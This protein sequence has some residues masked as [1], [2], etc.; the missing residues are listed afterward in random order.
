MGDHGEGGGLEG[1][2]GLEAV[3]DREATLRSLLLDDLAGSAHE[4]GLRASPACERLV[5]RLTKTVLAW[6]ARKFDDAVAVVPELHVVFDGPPG[7][8]SGRFV[9]VEI[10]KG[11]G[12]W[13]SAHAGEWVERRDGYWALVLKGKI[14]LPKRK[15]G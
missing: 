10:P 2:E 8:V 6:E 5:D 15:Q 7:P 11:N 1:S 12:V 13:L 9:E 3:S 4:T 14:A